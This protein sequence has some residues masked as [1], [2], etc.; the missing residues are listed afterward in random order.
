MD[1]IS[2]KYQNCKVTIWQQSDTD[3]KYRGKAKALYTGKTRT[4]GPLDNEAELLSQMYDW[5]KAENTNG[6]PSWYTRI[7]MFFR[8]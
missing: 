4:F 3:K 1:N 6:K 5:V 7:L 2:N 8:W